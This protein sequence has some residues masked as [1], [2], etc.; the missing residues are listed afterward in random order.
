MTDSEDAR[1][2][3]DGRPSSRRRGPIF[4]Q[5]RIVSLRLED[6]LHQEMMALCDELRTPA[7]TYLTDLVKADLKKRQQLK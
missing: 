3:L 7:N 4:K 6:D 1:D 5:R 2:E